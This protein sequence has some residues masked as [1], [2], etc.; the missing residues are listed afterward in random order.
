MGW[1]LWYV[2]DRAGSD[3]TWRLARSQNFVRELQKKMQYDPGRGRGFRSLAREMNIGVATVKLVLNENLRY[4]SCK[5]C[6]ER[7]LIATAL[8]TF[9]E[10]KKLLNELKKS[11]RTG[12]LVLL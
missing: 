12:T 9:E 3:R 11:G 4:H 1:N 2:G 6:E 10:G 7:L 8:K 5:M